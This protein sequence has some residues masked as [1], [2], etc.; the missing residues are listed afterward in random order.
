METLW[1]SSPDYIDSIQ[2]AFVLEFDGGGY[3]SQQLDLDFNPLSM[4]FHEGGSWVLLSSEDDRTIW[5]APVTNGVPGVAEPILGEQLGEDQVWWFFPDVSR[6]YVS[7]VWRYEDLSRSCELVHLVDGA[8]DWIWDFGPCAGS[9]APIIRNNQAYFPLGDADN[10]WAIWQVDLD[11][12]ESL[13]EPISGMGAGSL[14]AV[15]SMG[16]W[17][18]HSQ[19]TGDASHYRLAG[20]GQ[21]GVS[22]VLEFDGMIAKNAPP[23]IVP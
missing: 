13:G 23:R 15:S 3:T 12:P 9:G 8:V 21:P 4:W 17:V 16:E 22:S 19:G 5:A 14:T 2:D 6:S 20:L 18:I 1:G 10:N 7:V 11:D